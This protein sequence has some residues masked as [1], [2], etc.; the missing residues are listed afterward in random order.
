MAFL[1][2]PRQVTESLSAD[3]KSTLDPV[4][5]TVE[6]LLMLCDHGEAGSS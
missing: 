1:R 4:P 6:R 2:I 3:G 5:V